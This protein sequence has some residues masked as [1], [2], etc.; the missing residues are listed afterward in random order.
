MLTAHESPREDHT[1]GFLAANMLEFEEP[2]FKGAAQA[3]DVSQDAHA[4]KRSHRVMISEVQVSIGSVVNQVEDL[5]R[6]SGID[7]GKT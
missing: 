2:L 3:I 1:N 5:T 6:Q 7:K 4:T